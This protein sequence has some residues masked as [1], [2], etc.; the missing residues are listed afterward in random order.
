MNFAEFLTNGGPVLTVHL[1]ALN[2]VAVIASFLA[3]RSW[4]RTATLGTFSLSCLVQLA[5]MVCTL[6]TFGAAGL[7]RG[8]YLFL[9]S[10][11]MLVT[12]MIFWLRKGL[13]A[14]ALIVMPVALLVCLISLF[15]SSH[16]GPTVPAS[17]SAMFTVMHVGALLVSFCLIGTGFGAG[18][19]FLAQ[20]KHI[21]SKAKL[22][23]LHRELPNL[24]SLDKANA[25][26]TAIGFPLYSLGLLFGFIGARF[27]WGTLL[28]F[29][30]KEL[31]SIA[32][33][34]LFAWLFHQRLA[35]DWKGRKPAVMMIILFLVN[36][37]SLFGVN[38]FMNTHHG[39]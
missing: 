15:G 21:K 26:I 19:V 8:F 18:L 5:T 31:V 35:R 4:L 29:D 24:N 17:F 38:F 27:A 3:R 9:L 30:P 39:F 10:W 7:E 2:V 12:S 16:T 28:N 34:A 37:F 33:W 11:G 36:A 6:L 22:S 32:C 14:L 25:I 20:E 23:P 13:A 1:L